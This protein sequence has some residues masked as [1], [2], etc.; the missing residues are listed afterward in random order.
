MEFE[1]KDIVVMLNGKLK[2]LSIPKE[3]LLIF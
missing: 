1:E 2:Y 3:K